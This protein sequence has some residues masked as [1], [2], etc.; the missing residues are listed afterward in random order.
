[1]TRSDLIDALALRFDAI[2][3]EDVALVVRTI[4]DAMTQTLAH[5][6]RVEVRGFGSFGL[7]YR[8]ARTGRN[9]M[10]GETVP[11][12]AKYVPAFKAG[13]EL[14]EH[15]AAQGGTDALTVEAT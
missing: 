11:V 2:P 1:M 14:R 9:P 5:G 12:P 8:A 13:K 15:L 3:H 4:L 6:Q 10:T 7:H